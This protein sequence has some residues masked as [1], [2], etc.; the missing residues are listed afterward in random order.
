[1]VKQVKW[2]PSEDRYL[3]RNYARTDMD[4]MERY[5]KRSKGSIRGRAYKLGIRRKDHNWKKW[6]PQEDLD[7]AEMYPTAS[8]NDMVDHFKRTDKSIVSHAWELGI[9]RTVPRAKQR[10]VRTKEDKAYDEIMEAQRRYH[11][12]EKA[13]MGIEV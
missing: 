8:I 2:K 1:M 5:L 9:K 6:R 4:K 13:K 7:L 11:A 3:I 12:R 10:R